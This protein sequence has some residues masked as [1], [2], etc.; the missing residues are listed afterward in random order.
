MLTEY[1]LKLF[2]ETLSS[3][4][5]RLNSYTEVTTV[6]QALN[7][8]VWWTPNCL[9][10]HNGEQKVTWPYVPTSTS[11][12]PSWS[13]SH[14]REHVTTSLPSDSGSRWPTQVLKQSLKII[15]SGYRFKTECMTCDPSYAQP[16][17]LL[18]CTNSFS[19]IKCIPG[20]IITVMESAIRP[21]LHPTR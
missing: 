11:F 8:Q 7:T 13:M 16:A 17:T 2:T 4:K 21:V 14:T 19:L 5:F 3:A 9:K 6:R 10:V 1:R 15:Y 18:L 12:W 20:L